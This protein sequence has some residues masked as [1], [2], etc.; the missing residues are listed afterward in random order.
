MSRRKGQRKDVRRDTSL[1][2]ASKKGRF[3]ERK[4]DSNAYKEMHP[5]EKPHTE[6]SSTNDD[7][8]YDG[9]PGLLERA[10]SK[11]F[12]MPAGIPSR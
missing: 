8:W 4:Y 10:A 5:D 6:Q 3:K 12:N 1:K 11:S 7:D 9:I 2:N